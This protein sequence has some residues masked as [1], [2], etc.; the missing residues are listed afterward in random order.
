[1]RNQP[2]CVFTSRPPSV[3]SAP[4]FPFSARL[5]SL[6]SFC[7]FCGEMMIQRCYLLLQNISQSMCVCLTT[8]KESLQ[9]SLLAKWTFDDTKALCGRKRE[10]AVFVTLAEASTASSL[11]NNG[12][13][14][15]IS[16][17]KKNTKK[18]L[19]WK[20]QKFERFSPSK[21]FKFPLDRNL[22]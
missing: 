10:Y 3:P 1:M 20:I 12:R 7:V 13:H 15:S 16:G 8:C 22:N 5:F 4:L 14:C 19:Y 9:D 11:L 21:Q 18:N 17:K 2:P 6:F